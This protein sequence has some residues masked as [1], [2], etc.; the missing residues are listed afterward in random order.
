M[1]QAGAAPVGMHRPNPQLPRSCG[2]LSAVAAVIGALVFADA[3][4][5]REMQKIVGAP[6]ARPDKTLLPVVAFPSPSKLGREQIMRLQSAECLGGLPLAISG[7]LLYRDRLVVVQ[8]GPRQP[9]KVSEGLVVS[10]QES[11][12]VLGRK[13]DDEAIIRMGQIEARTESVRLIW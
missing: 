11:L 4:E 12:A 13:R 5:S 7:N 2:R 9:A 1:A 10:F 8:D 6:Q 3:F